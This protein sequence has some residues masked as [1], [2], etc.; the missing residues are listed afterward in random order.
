MWLG[1]QRV[2]EKRTMTAPNMFNM[3]HGTV[4]DTGLYHQLM[5]QFVAETTTDIFLEVKDL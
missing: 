3:P 5:Q 4:Q 2:M 1:G